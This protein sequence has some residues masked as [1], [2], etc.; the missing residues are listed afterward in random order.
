MKVYE[1]NILT[2]DAQDHVYK[3]LVE[4]DGK[5]S[6]VGDEL[7]AKYASGTY[8][9]LGGLRGSPFLLMRGI[10]ILGRKNAPIHPV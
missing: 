4:E 9:K 1:G 5:I 10:V 7:P 3:Y 2:C 8:V 6:F